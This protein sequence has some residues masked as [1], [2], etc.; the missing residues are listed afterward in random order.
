MLF[1]EH[2]SSFDE[3]FLMTMICLDHG[4]ILKDIK[5]LVLYQDGAEFMNKWRR[6]MVEEGSQL[7]QVYLEKWPLNSAYLCVKATRSQLLR[8]LSILVH[9]VEFEMINCLFDDVCA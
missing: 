2:W 3:I 7:S 5:A 8:S 1:I 6:K 9:F 4:Q